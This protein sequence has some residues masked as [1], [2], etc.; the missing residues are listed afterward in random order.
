MLRLKTLAT[1]WPGSGEHAFGS[2]HWPEPL[3]AS[4]PV[5]LT[6]EQTPSE[7][8]VPE[9]CAL[10]AHPH[11]PG[12]EFA[13]SPGQKSMQLGSPSPSVSVS[14]TPHPQT[15]G[16][17]LFLSLGHP[18]WQSETPSPSESPSGHRTLQSKAPRLMRVPNETLI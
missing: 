5:P 1:Q 3:H 12:C 4:S 6:P 17:V 8:G 2:P 11:C 14:A 18:S 7:H 10:P 9:G 13:G 15:P 16:D